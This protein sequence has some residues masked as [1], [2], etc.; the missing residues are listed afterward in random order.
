MYFVIRYFFFATFRIV[1][2]VGKVNFLRKC[3]VHELPK[4]VD[5]GQQDVLAVDSPE[6]DPVGEQN[7]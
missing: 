7:R 2:E 4:V 6:E 3:S 1:R 5:G